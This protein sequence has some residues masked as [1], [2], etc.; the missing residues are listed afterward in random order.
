MDNTLARVGIFTLSSISYASLIPFAIY[1]P[2][3]KPTSTAS[4]ED[5]VVIISMDWSKPWQFVESLE[6]WFSVLEKVLENS[7][8]ESLDILREREKEWFR[9]YKVPGDD[10][11]DLASVSSPSKE[12]ELPLGDGV[13]IKNLGIPVIVVCCKSDMMANL[14]REYSY[15]DDV[16]FD[17]I[18][19]TLRTICLK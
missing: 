3:S 12:V 13:L 14:E 5:S 1:P 2:Q 4:W 8:G 16:Q 15:K 9:D 17:Y 19:L 18:Q 6:K 10:S 11:K 7:E